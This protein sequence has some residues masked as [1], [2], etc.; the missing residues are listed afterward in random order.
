MSVRESATA[1]ARRK[2]A[3][4]LPQEDDSAPKT[5]AARKGSGRWLNWA[6]G[7]GALLALGLAAHTFS[8]GRSEA[9]PAAERPMVRSNIVAAPG[10][11]ESV[12]GTL[13]L[14]FEIAGKLKQVD[15]KEGQPVAK[16]QL[17][18]ELVN[19]DHA[20][21]LAV[22]KADEA[23]AEAEYRIL[24]GNVKAELLRAQFEVDRLRADLERL[25]AGARIEELERARAEVKAAEVEWKRR[26]N[27]AQRYKDHPTVSSEQERVMTQG[28]AEITQAQYEAAQAKL[29]E[30]EAGTRKEDL[31]KA[32]AL[33]KAAAAD[34]DR[35][36]ETREAR[37]NAARGHVEQ[38]RGRTRTAEAELAKTQLRSPVDGVVVWKFRHTGESVLA[39]TPEPVVAVADPVRLRVRADVDEADFARIQPGMRVRVRAE[40]FGARDFAGRVDVV[41]A[42]A[43]QKRFSTGEA[44]ERQDVKVIE[45]IVT[46]DEQ[47]PFKLGLRVTAY[48]EPGP[49][50][51]ERAPA[52]TRP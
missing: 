34:L 48:F 16:G 22:A 49:Q 33:L 24:D 20:A 1:V 11:V 50:E 28:L 19:D 32:E 18:A 23:V 46:F 9:A 29:R 4:R 13:N 21:R 30:L 37:L 26:V 14:S 45:T 6:V 17:L 27:D 10:L 44:K 3:V 5:V 51:A 15:A 38:A 35:A 40:A 2:T 43:G 31:A 8:G 47:P 36:N 25:K 42:S 12:S 39:L 52:A 41:G 7:A